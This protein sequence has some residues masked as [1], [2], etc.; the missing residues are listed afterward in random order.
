VGHPEIKAASIFRGDGSPVEYVEI[1]EHP[2]FPDMTPGRFLSDPVADPAYR[3]AHVSLRTAKGL[4]RID[5]EP[6]HTH[7]ITYV[8]PCDELNGT[9]WERPDGVQMCDAPAIIYCNGERGNGLFERSGR[10]GVLKRA[11]G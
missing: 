10:I 4:L 3:R 5:F 9:Q 8:D 11:H 1:L 6:V 2:E 7:A